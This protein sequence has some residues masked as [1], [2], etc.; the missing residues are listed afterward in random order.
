MLLRALFFPCFEKKK[1]CRVGYDWLRKTDPYTAG[2]I[3]E[4]TLINEYF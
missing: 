3:N 1:T 2:N 4:P